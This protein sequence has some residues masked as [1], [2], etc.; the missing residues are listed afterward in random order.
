MLHRSFS[1]YFSLQPFYLFAQASHL[2]EFL[3][4]KIYAVFIVLDLQA[5]SPDPLA[6]T[7]VFK[8]GF[9]CVEILS[10]CTAHHEDCAVLQV[11]VQHAAVAL[12]LPGIESQKRKYHCDYADLIQHRPGCAADKDVAVSCLQAF[13]PVEFRYV[14]LFHKFITSFGFNGMQR[15]IPKIQLAGNVIITI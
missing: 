15:S 4:A 6:V 14:S 7:V 5:Q 1:Q 12:E 3:S 9:Q 8:D 13:E 11:I 2:F 10:L